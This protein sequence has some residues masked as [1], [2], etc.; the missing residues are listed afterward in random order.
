MTVRRFVLASALAV[1]LVATPA[2]EAQLPAKVSRI[3]FPSGSSPSD[4]SNP[5]GEAFRQGLR[6]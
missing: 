5:A 3:G 6:T 1:G 4:A 2:T